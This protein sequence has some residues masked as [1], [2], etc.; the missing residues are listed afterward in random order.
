PDLDQGIVERRAVA[1]EHPALNGDPLA[2]G[3]LG[4]E[5]FLPRLGQGEAEEGADRLRWRLAGHGQRSIGVA[6]RPRSTMSKR[7]P[8]AHSGTVVCMSKRETMRAAAFGSGM[9]L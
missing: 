8:S 2:D 4:H 1:V 9:P 7:K 5:H 6:S 3:R